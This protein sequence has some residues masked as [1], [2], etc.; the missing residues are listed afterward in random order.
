MKTNT[1]TANWA[2]QMAFDT[3][4]DQY[5]LRIDTTEEYGGADTGIRPKRLL[6][7]SLAGCT[8]LD[9]VSILNKMR[10]EYDSFSIQVEGTLTETEPSYYDKIHVVYL[11][12]GTDLL[13]D[14]L[15]RAADLSQEKYCGV[16]EMLR[17][18]AEI[19]YEV[20]IG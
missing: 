8:G 20:K 14:K 15:Q 7:A 2:G 11:F 19:T 17:K 13:M 12:T 18:A 3:Q 1:I 9:V 6:L 16:S 10:I 4:I 5:S